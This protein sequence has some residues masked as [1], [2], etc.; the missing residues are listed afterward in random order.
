MAESFEV[1]ARSCGARS[2]ARR[3]GGKNAPYFIVVR[4]D[5]EFC[6]PA[7]SG[8]EIA[9]PAL[10]ASEQTR[11]S[12]FLNLVSGDI[13]NPA[14]GAAENPWRLCRTTEESKPMAKQHRL[15]TFRIALLSVLIAC[16]NATAADTY[17]AAP[18]IRDAHQYFASLV[19]DD[20]VTAIY[21][22]KSQNGNILGYERFPADQYSDLVCNS[23]ITLKN[24]TKIDIDW[25]VVEKSQ[26][27]S[28]SLSILHGRDVQFEFFHMLS[29]EGGIVVE[30]SN[31]IPRLI[32]GISDEL[33]RNRLSKAMDLMSAACRSKSK[34]D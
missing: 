5:G 32:F 14:G 33:S 2:S 23:G 9:P 11:G 20:H 29:V 16:L 1:D 26:P 10:F 19:S 24:G 27:S 31:A 25:S 30:P 6:A 4:E 12:Q 8:H 22:T 18:T 13:A 3:L 15:S 17:P 7:H 34:F 21:E 28:G